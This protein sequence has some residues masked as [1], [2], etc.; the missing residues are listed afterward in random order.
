MEK[1]FKGTS[2]T[3]FRIHWTTCPPSDVLHSQIGAWGEE[4][5]K[6]GKKRGEDGQRGTP[7]KE[8]C[9]ISSKP[10]VVDRSRKAI[11]RRIIF[12]QRPRRAPASLP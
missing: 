10:I 8:K 2:V 12:G 3:A 9:T 11:L 6:G 5:W 1:L 4:T 7:P